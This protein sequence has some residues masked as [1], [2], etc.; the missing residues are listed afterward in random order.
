MKPREPYFDNL[1]CI[2]IYLVTAG[3]FLLPLLHQPLFNKVFHY[4]YAFHMPSFIFVSGYFAKSVCRD[5]KFRFN[6]VV[7]V[8]WL[9]LLFKLLVYPTENLAAGGPWARFDLF[10]ESGAPWYLLSLSLWYLTLP[11]AAR[12]KPWLMITVSVIIGLLCGYVDSIHYFLSL[13]RTLAFAPFF[14]A[15]YYIQK[16]T[17]ERLLAP[18][19]RIF[20][21]VLFIPASVL[22]FK[23]VSTVLGQYSAVVYGIPYRYMGQAAAQGGLV[24]L[25]WYI[26]AAV[27]MLG[28][29][30]LIPNR[31]NI[32]TR[33][34]TNTL[35]IYVLHRPIRDLCQYY[36]IFNRPELSG[37]TGLAIILAGSAVLVLFLSNPLFTAVFNFISGLPARIFKRS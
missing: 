22:V 23:G 9:Y 12:V 6:K 4:I 14:Y 10:T 30:A 2:L 7:T 15:G 5:G 16:G 33:L 36:G 11:A 28:C 27:L 1:K 35:Q 26:L 3:H 29:M 24:R 19:N 25:C 32:L 17:I 21:L 18:R 34:G 37:R 20:A 31:E 8:L 13:S